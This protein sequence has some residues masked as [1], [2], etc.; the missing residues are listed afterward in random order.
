MIFRVGHRSCM[1]QWTKLL[2]VYSIA[3][4]YSLRLRNVAIAILGFATLLSATHLGFA[5]QAQPQ[6]AQPQFKDKVAQSQPGNPGQQLAF[7]SLSVSI[8]AV[9]VSLFALY[10]N[11]SQKKGEHRAAFYHAVVVYKA[12]ADIPAFH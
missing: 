12:V 4:T 5:V 2:T 10:R 1:M 3:R 8:A 6:F 7:Y 9:V 11:L